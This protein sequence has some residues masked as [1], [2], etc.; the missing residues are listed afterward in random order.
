VAPGEKSVIYDYLIITSPP[1][2]HLGRARRSLTTMQ[3]S[4]H[5]LQWDAPLVI[6]M[7][8]PNSPRKQPLPF[9]DHHHHL[10]RPSLARPYT[11]SKMASGSNQPFCHSTL[12]GRQTDTHRPTDGLDDRSTASGLALTLAILIESDVL[13]RG[14]QHL[15]MYVHST[16]VA[17]A[18]V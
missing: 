6:T 4:P 10:I 12:S 7:G 1:Q 5:W 8:R 14:L 2:S 17:T 15:R 9:D 18:G 3:Q 11:S 13:L 16:D